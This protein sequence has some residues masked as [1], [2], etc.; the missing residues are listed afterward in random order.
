MSLPNLIITPFKDGYGMTPKTSSVMTELDGGAPRVRRTTIGATKRYPVTFVCSAGEY[1]YL[2]KFFYTITDEGSK[3][4]TLQ[5]ESDGSGLE[6]HTAYFVPGSY[7]LSSKQGE[8]Y[9][10]N[11][12]LDAEPTTPRDPAFDALYIEFFS[13]YGNDLQ[14]I[15]LYSERLVNVTAPATD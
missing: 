15:L 12:Q 14:S 8:T 6:E 5:M 9:F 3:P 13:E 10:V 4:F 11:A 7:R 1:L 2:D